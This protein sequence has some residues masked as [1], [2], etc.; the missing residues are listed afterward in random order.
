M[1]EKTFDF[2]CNPDDD[3]QCE[4]IETFTW[5]W[6][7]ELIIKASDAMT[8]MPD[9]VCDVEGDCPNVDRI[10]SILT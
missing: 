8:F 3:T 4:Q 6:E 9:I 2:V 5:T 7:Q 1:A 10:K